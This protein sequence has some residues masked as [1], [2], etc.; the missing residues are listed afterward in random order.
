MKQ[1]ITDL[2]S[3]IESLEEQLSIKKKTARRNERSLIEQYDSSLRELAAFSESSKASLE[4]TVDELKEKANKACEFSKQLVESISESEKQNQV[5]AEENSTLSENQ[6][7]FIALVL[8]LKPQLAKK[9]PHRHAQFASANMFCE[10]K[11]QVAALQVKS[12]YEKIAKELLNARV[13]SVGEFYDLDS[14]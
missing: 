8:A 1:M 6:K 4:Q 9:R 14:N 3:H 2:Q 11:V 5:F 10:T 12:K 13:D 7:N